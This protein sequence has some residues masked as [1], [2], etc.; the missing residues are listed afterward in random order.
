M[1]IKMH[2]PCG[3]NRDLMVFIG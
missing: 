1:Q 2:N 3:F